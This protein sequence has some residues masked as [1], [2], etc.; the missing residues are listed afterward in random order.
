MVSFIKCAFCFGAS[1]IFQK[2]TLQIGLMVSTST[3]FLGWLMWKYKAFMRRKIYKR[4]NMK[5]SNDI[6]CL[7]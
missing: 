2:P 4:C 5:I 1:V 6:R 7:V 3:S